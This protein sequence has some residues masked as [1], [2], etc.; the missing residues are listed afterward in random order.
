MLNGLYSSSSA[1]NINL[2]NQDLI[3]HNLAHVNVP[4]FKR[5]VQHVSTFNDQFDGV[6]ILNVQYADGSSSEPPQNSL[7]ING[8][9]YAD[10]S[11]DHTQGRLEET[12][13]ELNVA[14]SGKGFFVVQGPDGPLYT[15]N[16][17][18]KLN[19]DNQL[20]L[21]SGFV[22]EGEG[23]PIEIIDPQRTTIRSDGTIES[24]G[25]EIGKLRVVDFDNANR[26]TP[27]GTTLFE[28]ADAQQPFPI[29]ESET[30]LQQGFLE[31]SNTQAINELIRMIAGIRHFESAQKA[32]SA[33][34]ESIGKHT[35]TQT[36]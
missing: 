25:E 30:R 21:V 13:D 6:D 14:I 8:V 4:G 35:S 27:A 22:V 31:S 17:N 28:A 9:R 24:A 19:Q 23:G 34:S 2:H 5:A 16:G 10:Y 7:N 11:I 18:F 32:L 33:I 15:R 29:D 1:L 26:L 36:A 20:T 3:S 12:G